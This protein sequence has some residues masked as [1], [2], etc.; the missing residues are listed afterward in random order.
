MTEREADKKTAE[1]HAIFN[2]ITLSLADRAA[3]LK[4]AMLTFEKL[5]GK[6]IRNIGFGE[7]EHGIT[8]YF[9]DDTVA[10]LGATIDHTVEIEWL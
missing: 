10:F 1:F 4:M 5:K 6:T 7:S 9:T 2:D 8:L 3:A